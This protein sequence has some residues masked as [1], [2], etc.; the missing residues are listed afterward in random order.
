MALIDRYQPIPTKIEKLLRDTA[1]REHTSAQAILGAIIFPHR[2]QILRAEDKRLQVV[3]VLKDTSYGGGHE[4]LAKAN[5]IA[6]EHAAAF[7]EVMRGNLDCSNLKVEEL[8]A[9]VAWEVKLADCGPRFLRQVISHF[10]VD[11]VWWNG[12]LAAPAFFNERYKF[13]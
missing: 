2:D 13:T 9:K 6:N 1:E 5:Y 12:L 11:L 3:V 4:R 10:E 8:I 7:V